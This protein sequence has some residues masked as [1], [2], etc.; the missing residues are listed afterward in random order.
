MVE[1]ARR[2]LLASP[3]L[4]AASPMPSVFDFTLDALEGRGLAV[5]HQTQAWLVREPDSLAKTGIGGCPGPA[6]PRLAGR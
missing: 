6:R 3:L 4:M 5:L 2:A 1:I